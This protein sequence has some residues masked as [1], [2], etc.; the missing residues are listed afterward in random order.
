MLCFFFCP[1]S[2]CRR[3]VETVGLKSSAAGDERWTDCGVGPQEMEM[4]PVGHFVHCQSKT[5]R[6]VVIGQS[7]ALSL[8][9]FPWLWPLVLSIFSLRRLRLKAFHYRLIQNETGRLLSIAGHSRQTWLVFQ[10][11][12][13]HLK[14]HLAINALF[15]A[16]KPTVAPSDLLRI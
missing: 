13:V 6:L 7:V 3:Q 5:F 2:L 8:S 12:P 11:R 10:P 1:E 16:F 4:S 14:C 9:G 15:E